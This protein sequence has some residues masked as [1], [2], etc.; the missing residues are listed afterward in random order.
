MSADSIPAHLPDWIRDHL[1]RYLD[2]DGKDGHLWDASL[3][4]GTG[5]VPTLI[6]TT[7]GR[8]SGNALPLPLIYGEVEGGHV[9]I[10]SKGGAPTHPVWYLNL[11]ANPLVDVQVK[12]NKFRARA[13]VATGD[14]R[15][16]IWEQMVGIYAPYAEYQVRA[17]DREIPV[18]VL[19][20]A[21]D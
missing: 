16:K 8:K 18:V 5:M 17:G 2:S 7:T 12:A 11:E 14:E 1:K 9:V 15:A 6:L 19:E 10:A 13:R 20:P 21:S 3:G 4:G